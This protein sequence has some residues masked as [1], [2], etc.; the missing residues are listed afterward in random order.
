MFGWG[1]QPDR[2]Q[3]RRETTV[4]FVM[5]QR[6][7]CPLP[8]WDPRRQPPGEERRC[9]PEEGQLQKGVPKK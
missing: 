9:T 4:P 6:G 7:T 1:Q 3:K 8:C 5:G 2:P